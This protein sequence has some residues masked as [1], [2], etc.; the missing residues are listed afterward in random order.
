[1]FLLKAN[2]SI[3]LPEELCSENIP[4]YCFQIVIIIII[5]IIICPA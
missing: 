1:M 4:F 5:I 2:L 3:I